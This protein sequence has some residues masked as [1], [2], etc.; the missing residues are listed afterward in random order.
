[1]PKWSTYQTG[2]FLA[3]LDGDEAREELRQAER[4]V[5]A[6]SR[7]YKPQMLSSRSWTLYF[8][9]SH[10]VQGCRLLINMFSQLFRSQKCSIAPTDWTIMDR[11]RRTVTAAYRTGI[12]AR[13]SCLIVR[14][15]A[16]QEILQLQDRT[17]GAG[18]YREDVCA[19]VV[20]SSV[21]G[22]RMFGVFFFEIVQGEAPLHYG[23]PLKNSAANTRE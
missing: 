23:P 18:L 12:I 11:R 16:A 20:G 6:A 15:Q 5:A 3:S 10:E 19:T 17:A 7:K 9:K 1:M 4:L 21:V 8:M 14:E 22:H 13:S 2:R